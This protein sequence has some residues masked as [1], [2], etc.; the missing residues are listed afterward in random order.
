MKTNLTVG[1]DEGNKKATATVQKQDAGGKGC[2]L[3]RPATTLLSPFTDPYRKKRTLT[4]LDASAPEACFDPT[5]W[6]W[7]M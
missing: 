6:P 1:G 4:D 5:K 2:R 7:T 3:K